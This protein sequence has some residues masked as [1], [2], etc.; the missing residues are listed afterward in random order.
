MVV[1]LLCCSPAALGAGA[2][3]I[4]AAAFCWC[5]FLLLLL[6]D[7]WSHVPGRPPPRP[8]ASL[9]RHAC[10]AADIDAAFPPAT[11]PPFLPLTPCRRPPT[12]P[13][14]GPPPRS[15][16]ERKAPP[17]STSSTACSSL[18]TSSSTGAH[19]APSLSG[20]HGTCLS[21]ASAAAGGAHARARQLVVHGQTWLSPQVVP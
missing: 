12:S 8:L 3:G 15:P 10:A 21:R 20:P 11:R 18:A 1:L 17:S 13:S 4:A 6:V 9:A 14:E 16:S 5:C 2:A 19:G 7:P